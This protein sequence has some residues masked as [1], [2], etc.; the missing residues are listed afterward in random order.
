MKVN[1]K[2]LL[3]LG[4]LLLADPIS[5]SNN[6]GTLLAFIANPEENEVHHPPY[7]SRLYHQATRTQEC[8]LAS[9]DTSQAALQA[10][11]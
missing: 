7:P 5:N 2:S 11:P 10:F 6:A 9:S 8:M 3:K 1:E 4:E